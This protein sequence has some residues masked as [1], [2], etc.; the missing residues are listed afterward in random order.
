MTRREGK[1]LYGSKELERIAKRAAAMADR[2]GVTVA[3]AGGLA[4]QYYGSDRLTGDVD[5]LADDLVPESRGFKRK[6]R[7]SFGGVVLETVEGIH[8]DVIVRDDAQAGLY[9]HALDAATVS[10]FGVPIISPEHLAAIK[11][12]AGRP[13]D[14]SDLIFLLK[15]MKSGEIGKARNLVYRFLGGAWPAEEFDRVVDEAE[16]IKHREGRL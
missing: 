3:V 13:K 10:D 9:R 11:F 12:A 8:V 6:G 5:F 1:A 2:F 7:I 15:S 16:W 14:Q 4:M